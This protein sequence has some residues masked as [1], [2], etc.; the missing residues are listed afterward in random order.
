MGADGAPIQVIMG[1]DGAPIQ[2]IMHAD[3]APALASP[4]APGDQRRFPSPA[5]SDISRPR[6]RWS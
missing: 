2:V 5:A 3:G 6:P 1:A 4:G